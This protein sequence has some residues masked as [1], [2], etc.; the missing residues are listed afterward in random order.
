MLWFYLAIS[1]AFFSACC[2]ITCKHSLSHRVTGPAP[3]MAIV[4]SFNLVYA[5][6]TFLFLGGRLIAPAFGIPALISGLLSF[7]GF[8]A[9]FSALAREEASRI[10]G[11]FHSFPLVVTILA[12]I[13]LGEVLTPALYLA[14]CLVVIGS[15]LLSFRHEVDD[16]GKRKLKKISGLW[17]IFAAIA[18]LSVSFVVDKYALL[19]IAYNHY[20]LWHFLGYGIAGGAFALTKT[21][22]RALR[23]TFQK[24]GRATPL[25]FIALAEVFGIS[26]FVA[27]SLATMLGPVSLV[28]AV[29][30]TQPFFVLLIA[31]PL[32]YFIP[33]VINE[34]IDR[35]TVLF[36]LIGIIVI[37]SGI[38]LI[39]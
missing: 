25:K 38:Y 27:R 19:N 9:I 26:N 37:I 23:A 39:S 8:F 32:S 24:Y 20:L 4:G 3:I 16:K 6:I 35:K 33:G 17:A 5:L 29:T 14:I 12:V 34:K 11:L 1:A 28:S 18:I 30:S 10:V 2:A 15:S 36:K 7:V 13:F 22:R 21:S 31:V